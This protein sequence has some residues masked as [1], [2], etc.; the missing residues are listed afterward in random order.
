MR[1]KLILPIFRKDVRDAIRDAR[2]LVAILV[3]LGLGLLYGQIFDDEAPKLSIN[4]AYTAAET[5]T[6]PDALRTAAGP[7]V[8]LTFSTFDSAAA[9]REQV[10][11]EKADLGL[12]I[13]AGFDAAV[14]Q[15]RSPELTVIRTSATNSSADFALSLL[16]STLRTMAGQTPPATIQTDVITASDQGAGAI[17]EDLGPRRYALLAM[18]VMLIAM[19]GMLVVPVILAE[20]AE[21]KTL[22]A[23]VMVASYT[24]V[25]A[26][27]ALVGLVYMVISLGF[28]LSLTGLSPANPAL[29]VA[30]VLAL[31]VTMIAFGLLLGAFFK[32]ANQLNTWSGFIILPVIAPVFLVGLGMPRPVELLLKVLPTSQAGQLLINALSGRDYF[33]NVWLGFVVILAWGLAAFLLLARLLQ[34][35]EA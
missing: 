34:R 35:R 18:V 27:K 20:E 26:A 23:L 7:A 5:T 14:R 21:K 13:P 16:D 10:D 28:L 6:L 4:I 31:S 2:V 3:P 1:L 30:A 25:I 22:D 8:E 15:G 29:F 24:D 9:V 12:V 17:F 11:A 32:N 33:G 19:I